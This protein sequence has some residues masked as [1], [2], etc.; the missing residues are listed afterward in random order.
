MSRFIQIH[1][2]SSYPAVLLNRDDAGL[3]K[4]LPYGGAPRIRVSSQCLKRHWRVAEDAWSLSAI[5]KPMAERSRMAVERAITPALGGLAPDLVEAIRV[6]LVRTLYGKDAAKAAGKPA[7]EARNRQ[8]LL[9]GRV[10]LDYLTR[11]ARE[12]AATGDAKS[13]EKLLAERFRAARAKRTS[14]R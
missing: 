6:S 7:E 3:A 9:L 4:R 1:T 13:A 10:E 2:L 12:A 5:G 14:R 11:L 8:A